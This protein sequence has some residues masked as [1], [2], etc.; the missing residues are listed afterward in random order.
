MDIDADSRKVFTGREKPPADQ[1]GGLKGWNA[2]EIVMPFFQWCYTDLQMCAGSPFRL[3]AKFYFWLWYDG[4]NG[5][6]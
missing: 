6:I 3:F 5:Q 2:T 1:T 4:E